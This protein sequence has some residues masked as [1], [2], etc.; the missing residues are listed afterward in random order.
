MSKIYETG[1][2]KNVANFETLIAYIIGYGSIYKPS[3]VSINIGNMQGQV[4]KAKDAINELHV[5]LASLG[6]AVAAREI[7][8]EPIN[9]LGTRLLNALKAT[10]TPTQVIENLATLNRK[11]Q[12]KRASVKLTAEEKAVLAGEGKV[13]NQI[14]TSQLSY[15]SILDNFDKLIKL[16]ASIPQYKPN[17]MELKVT[18]L[19]SLYSTLKQL[20]ATVVAN[21]I[22]LSNVRLLRN[23]IMYNVETGIVATAQDVKTY[24]KSLFGA[25]SVQYKQISGLAFKMMK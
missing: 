19:T 10:D 14:S 18:T 22:A 24:V 17:E 25:S 2:A 3:K 23:D 5:L 15:D 9:K 20:N 12:G 16:L 13:V 8:F 1:H 6:N 7:G 21:E 4:V 11:L